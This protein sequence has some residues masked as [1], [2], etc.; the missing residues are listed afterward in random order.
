MR[1][2]LEVLIQKTDART[3][4][5]RFALIV[6]CLRD[7]DPDLKT[8]IL[9]GILGVG[10]MRAARQRGGKATDWVDWCRAWVRGPQPEH[11]PLP[12]DRDTI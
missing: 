10:L 6:S 7:F 2:L 5:P 9:K 4:F 3:I 8:V 1:P 12:V 11:S